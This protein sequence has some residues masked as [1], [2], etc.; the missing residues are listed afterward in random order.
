[1]HIENLFIRLYFQF[2]GWNSNIRS[3]LNLSLFSVFYALN[4]SKIKSFDSGLVYWKQNWQWALADVSSCRRNVFIGAA[5]FVCP[6]NSPRYISV[7]KSKI[8]LYGIYSLD[9]NV[10]ETEF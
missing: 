4:Y 6:W 7:H 10:Y 5:D 8:I 2:K 1:M 9:E 3:A